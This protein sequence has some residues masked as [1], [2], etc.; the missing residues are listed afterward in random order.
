VVAVLADREGTSAG[1]LGNFLRGVVLLN[2][3]LCNEGLKC[4]LDAREA[5]GN[6]SGIH[7]LS[8]WL[9]TSGKC[10]ETVGPSVATTGNLSGYDCSL[11]VLSASLLAT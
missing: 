2:R 1:D 7:V 11:F 4:L 10:L 9:E 3:A 8:P 6:V 5:L